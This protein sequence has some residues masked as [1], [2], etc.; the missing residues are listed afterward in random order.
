M[1]QLR[2]RSEQNQRI[3][4]CDYILLRRKTQRDNYRY[5]PGTQTGMIRGRKYLQLACD[6]VCVRVDLEQ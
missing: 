1:W 3:L 2:L 6:G 4:R 5:I